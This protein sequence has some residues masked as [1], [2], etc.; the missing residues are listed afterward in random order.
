MEPISIE[1]YI[2]FLAQRLAPGYVTF[3]NQMNLTDC[4]KEVSLL[5]NEKG[6][7]FTESQDPILSCL[8]LNFARQISLALQSKQDMEV[9][10]ACLKSQYANVL[11]E[12]QTVGKK[13]V[14]YLHDLHSAES[15]LCS[16]REELFKLK[17]GCQPLSSLSLLSPA[18]PSLASLTSPLHH[19]VGE[20]GVTT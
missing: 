4:R 11:G 1:D 17:S 15:D 3:L 14:K 19:K 12:L 6:H 5:I 18:C 8:V 16:Y 13:A 7:S 20:G 9:E 2:S 10:M